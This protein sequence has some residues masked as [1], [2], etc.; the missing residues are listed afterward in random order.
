MTFPYLIPAQPMAQATAVIQHGEVPSPCL[1]L[2]CAKGPHEMSQGSLLSQGNGGD[3]LCSGQFPTRSQDTAPREQRASTRSHGPSLPSHHFA[4]SHP[5]SKGVTR[6]AGSITTVHGIHTSQADVGSLSP[7]CVSCC[8]L[9]SGSSSLSWCQQ[10][11]SVLQVPL[12]EMQSPVQMLHS[13]W[14]D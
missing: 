7:Q 13:V 3:S 14:V 6:P 8:H 2:V 5:F 10:Q 12:R 11:L 9:S 1:K 4:E